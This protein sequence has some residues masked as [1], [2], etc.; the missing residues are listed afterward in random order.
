MGTLTNACNAGQLF[1][2]E[3]RAQQKNMGKRELQLLRDRLT[4]QTLAS[5]KQR[6]TEQGYLIICGERRP[7]NASL[8]LAF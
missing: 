4:C 8:D 6:P 1:F 2:R 7:L 5:E 3:R